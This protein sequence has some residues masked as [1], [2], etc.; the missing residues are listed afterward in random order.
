MPAS[1]QSTEL[2]RYR[3]DPLDRRVASTLHQQ[4]DLQHFYCKSRLASEIQGAQH[5]SIFQHDDQ[6]LAQQS[7][8]KAK[9]DTT[10]L[11]TDQ[12]RSVLNTQSATQSQAFAYT[13][14][15]ERP[16]K[17]GLPSLLGFKG[18]RLDALTGNYDLGNGYRRYNTRLMRFDSPDSL[19]PFGEGGL[20]A[21]GFVAGDPVNLSDPTGHFP[22][23]KLL[24]GAFP[25][26][27]VSAGIAT[28]LIDD[29]DLKPVL[30]GITIGLTAATVALPLILRARPKQLGLNRSNTPGNVLSPNSSPAP[31]RP[32][33]RP[34]PQLNQIMG[35][36]ASE[37]SAFRQFVRGLPE[38]AQPPIWRDYYR[39]LIPINR[40]TIGS[41]SLQFHFPQPP[42]NSLSNASTSPHS[43]SESASSIR[44]FS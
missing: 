6:L 36:S 31:I 16:P 34:N 10:L 11:A 37:D 32:V 33:Q 44:S 23:S 7:S 22:V 5:R 35:R 42:R 13:P 29:K 18:E 41:T 19:S 30:L 20:N 39:G 3:Y 24:I 27:A 17:N 40:Q 8:Q 43:I 4:T 14:Y 1:P 38:E 12:Q 2:C 28:L 15:G 21:Y 26:G 9:V 25:V